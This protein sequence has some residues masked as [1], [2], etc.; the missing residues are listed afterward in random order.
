MVPVLVAGG[1]P[2][3]MTLALA[4][5]RLGVRCALVERNAHTTRHPKM[6][7]TNARSM[8]IFAALG[9]ALAVAAQLGET[10]LAFLVD[11]TWTEAELDQVASTLLE[12]LSDGAS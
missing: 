7:I 8:E 3:G 4:L 9:V 1:G 5:A 11:P 10:S 12:V 6:D 2:V